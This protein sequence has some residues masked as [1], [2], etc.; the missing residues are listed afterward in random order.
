MAF[1]KKIIL[2]TFLSL[3]FTSCTYLFQLEDDTEL[4]A[5][6]HKEIAEENYPIDLTDLKAI[7]WD[8]M[9]V[10]GPYTQ[11]EKVEQDLDLDLRNIRHHGIAYSDHLTLLVFLREGTSVNI[12]E[13]QTPIGPSREIIAK[14][15]CVFGKEKTGLSLLNR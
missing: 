3:A 9:I 10:L 12:V 7:D 11:I 4:S 1:K 13:L 15:D 14:K 6:L 2:F 5:F 8:S